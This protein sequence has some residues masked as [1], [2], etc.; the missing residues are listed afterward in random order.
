MWLRGTPA[1]ALCV[2]LA[3]TGQ[4]IWQ[5]DGKAL[6]DH[7]VLKRARHQIADAR[8]VLPHARPD[9]LILAPTG[10]SRTLL[11]LS[12]DTTTNSPRAFFT[13]ALAD[14]PAMHVPG[15]LRLQD[16]AD[17]GVGPNRIGPKRLAQLRT[18]LRVVGVDIACLGRGHVAARKVL[19]KLGWRLAETHRAACSLAGAANFSH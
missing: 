2:V 1:V 9:D 11:V 4:S 13:R 7:P 12:G 18:D 3:L 16:F 14:V 15:R 8:M 6:A 10:L 5:R 19:T 17:R